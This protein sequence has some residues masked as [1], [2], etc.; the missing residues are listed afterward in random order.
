MTH[1]LQITLE[2]RAECVVMWLRGRIDIESSS[3]WR[4]QLLAL[5][6]IDFPPET[7]VI[8]LSAIDYMDTSGLATL[9]EVLKIAT[10]RGM[11]MRLQGVQG[12]LLHLLQ[13]TGIGSLFEDTA[14][15]FSA[16]KVS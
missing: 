1:S 15:H 8:D 10:V 2:S 14:P 4:D 7:V 5:L 3:K 9:L 13:A 12:R 11:A 6:R 16:V